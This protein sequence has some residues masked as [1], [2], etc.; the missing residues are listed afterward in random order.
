M[1]LAYG[2]EESNPD[3]LKKI[4]AAQSQKESYITSKI[5]KIS[6]HQEE[7]FQK[8]LRERKLRTM[9]AKSRSDI[10]QTNDIADQNEIGLIDI[11]HK[12]QMMQ[13]RRD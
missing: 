3:A 9:T 13:N 4:I 5:E 8:R 6:N 11:K 12:I 7:T 1:R 2:A 10:F